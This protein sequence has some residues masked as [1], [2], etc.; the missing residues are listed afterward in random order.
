MKKSKESQAEIL[1]NVALI[2]AVCIGML[3]I[4]VSSILFLKSKIVGESLNQEEIIGDIENTEDF[5]SASTEFGKTV[6]DAKN[7]IE[8]EEINNVTQKTDND[9]SVQNKIEETSAKT[10][11]ND[12][13][14]KTENAKKQ[15]TENVE[16]KENAEVKQIKFEAPVKGEIIRE[17]ASDSL[18]YSETLQ[19]WITHKGIDIKADKTTVVVAACEGTVESIKN[20]PR[21]GLTVIINHDGG[22]KTVYSNLLTAEFVVQ[23]EKISGGQT[24]ATVGNSASFE[25][26]D[27]Y[28]LHFELLKDGEYQD[29]TIYMEF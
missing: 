6:D 21:Y 3:F 8:N 22:F 28:H 7:E 27:T 1:K 13:K 9:V 29:P 19:E 2:G 16:E 14:N 11:N 12:T 17:F 5:E 23:G 15:E 4:I 25:V 10:E 26:S 24:I 18:V 20:D